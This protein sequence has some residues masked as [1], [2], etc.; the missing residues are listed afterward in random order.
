MGRRGFIG[1][2]AALGAA[3]LAG[4]LAPLAR[5]QPAAG[6]PD[7]IA[8]PP[9]F[10][11][12][13]IAISPRG[14]AYT[15]SLIDGSIYR[16]DLATGAGRIVSPSPGQGAMSAGLK[17]DTYGRLLVAG[18]TGG[19]IRVVHAGDGRVLA[20]HQVATGA[21]FI[22][23]VIVGCGGAWFTDSFNDV[24]HFLPAGRD[25]TGAGSAPRPLALGGEWA[26]T[27]PGGQYWGANGIE[28]TPDGRA[29]LVVNDN[30]QALFRVD[31]RTGRATRTVL[32]GGAVGNGDGL[33]VLGRT[34]YV[35]RNW[36]YA[37]DVFTLDGD[38]RRARF[39]R[40]ITDPRFDEPTTAAMYGGR[41]YVVNA[42]F[43]ADWSDPA[44]ASTIVSC[45]L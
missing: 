4:P 1:A 27:P 7:A 33:V 39:V 24:L 34:L 22:N 5:A 35:V 38:G 43:D 15:G 9:G 3:A 28:R 44:T 2:A 14:T 41:L 21:T 13:G 12:E 6:R 42:R 37:I 26:P 31:P 40:Q 20:A 17:F 30:V 45:P 18:G 8:T 10:Q 29:L 32:D 36:A 19:Q 16:A 23:D 25:L 11:P